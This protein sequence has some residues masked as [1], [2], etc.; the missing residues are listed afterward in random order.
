MATLPLNADRLSEGRG[1]PP[2]IPR[3]TQIATAKAKYTLA[4][5]KIS[6]GTK[7]SSY[8]LKSDGAK[9]GSQ[10]LVPPRWPTGQLKVPPT[11]PAAG[12]ATSRAMAF[13]T[14]E[15]LK[16]TFP[17]VTRTT[18]VTVNFYGPFAPGPTTPPANAQVFPAATIVKLLPLTGAYWKA[19][20]DGL[21]KQARITKISNL[22]NAAVREKAEAEATLTAL[23]VAKGDWYGSS[24][25]DRTPSG[26]ND[27]SGTFSPINYDSLT[28]EYNVGM[29][30][31]AYFSSEKGFTELANMMTGGNRPSAVSTGLDLWKDSKSNKGMIWLYVGPEDDES[32]YEDVQEMSANGSARRYAFQF[33]YNPTTVQQAYTGNPEV[34]I[35]M[36]TSGKAR[37]NLLGGQTMSTVAFT[38]TLNRIFDMQYFGTDGLL[39]PSRRDEKNPYSPMKPDNATQKRIYDYG[40]MYDVEYLLSTILGVKFKSRFRDMTSDIGFLTGRPVDLHLGNKLR[41]W[42]YIQD[43]SLN[44]VIFDER[45]VPVLSEVNI[46]FARIPDYKA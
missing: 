3:N 30:N 34:D 13:N 29:V 9:S 40:T 8:Y 42:G 16:A 12:S 10:F 17:N 21:D 25:V 20:L 1:T 41:Y 5:D 19:A 45:M 46:T 43:I 44:H 24:A 32:V 14:R 39:K 6:E 37:Y 23:G 18:K 22:V 36:W 7:L 33:H 27:S 35:T 11:P 31:E 2:A 26:N 38:L 15:Y 28:V 4:V